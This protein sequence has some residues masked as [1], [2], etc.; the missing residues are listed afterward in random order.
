MNS[1]KV[2]PDIDNLYNVNDFI[3]DISP[4]NLQVDLIVEEIFVN[5]VNYS[6]TEYIIV[7]ADYS[8]DRLTIVFVDNGFEFNPLLKEN[9]AFPDN[10]E[11][12]EIGGLGIY[13]AKQLS[14]LIYYN[15]ID[16]ENQLTVIKTIEDE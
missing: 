14:D 2:E 5:I 6:K 1:I 4:E 16:G 11:E 12:S 15:Y 13:L 9:P 8:D 7:N 10:I 3:H